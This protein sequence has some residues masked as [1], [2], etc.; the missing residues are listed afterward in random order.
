MTFQSKLSR[1]DAL[2]NLARLS[3]GFSLLTLPGAR[4][5]AQDPADNP[6]DCAPPKPA[7]AAVPFVGGKIAVQPRKSAFALSDAEIA[8]LTLAWEK[9]REITQKDPNNPIGWLRQSYVHCW[10]CGGGTDGLQGEEIHSS[11]WFPPWHRCYLYF[12]ER[13]LVKVSGDPNLRLPYWDWSTQ[14]K[15]TQTFPPIYAKTTSSLYDALRK[16]KPGDLIPQAFVGPNAMSKVLNAPTYALFGGVDPT[17]N[18]GSPGNL[19]T[20]PHNNVHTWT[21]TKGNAKPTYGSDMGVLATAARDP[22]FFA[23]HAN[24]DRMW[25]S[26]LAVEATPP[27][28][29]PTDA[30]W[31]NHTWTFYDENGVWTSI[32][33]SDVLDTKNLGYVYDTLAVVPPAKKSTNVTAASSLIAAPALAVLAPSAQAKTLKDDPATHK[34]ALPNAHQKNLQALAD[35]RAQQYLLNIEGVVAPHDRSISAKVYVNLPKANAATSTEVPNFVGFISSVAKVRRGGSLGGHH[36]GAVRYSFVID[37]EL[38]AIV[39]RDGAVQVTLVP[40]DELAQK[41]K[42][43]SF[44]YKQISLLPLQ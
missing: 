36:H 14:S 18:G 20:I 1:R 16:V 21:G 2:L 33:V 26:W 6:V 27:H 11:W 10:S 43:S 22:V 5:W 9:L 7:G 15:A 25:P 34:I 13:M 42:G 31:L 28:A 8:S 39:A 12:L 4:A 23:H 19:E 37:A 24:V 40:V 17:I 30:S 35:G 3:A 38:A 32:K 41:S 29:N 44:T